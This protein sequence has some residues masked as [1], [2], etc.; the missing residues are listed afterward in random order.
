MRRSLFK[1][2]L[3]VLILLLLGSVPLL[4]QHH[5]DKPNVA[6]PE[7]LSV[8]PENLP[9]QFPG[10]FAFD[11]SPD[12]QTLAVEFIAANDQN[13]QVMQVAEWDIPSKK[14]K[15]TKVVEGP[16]KQLMSNPQ[17]QY[18]LRFTPDGLDL[19]AL[20]GP[21]L[22]ILNAQTLTP[23]RMIGLPPE[24]GPPPKFGWVL[25]SFGISGDG[26]K[27][28]VISRGVGPTCGDY[29]TFRLFGLNSEDLLD[30]WRFRGCTGSIS[31]SEDGTYA[32]LG[33]RANQVEPWRGDL[34]NT[35]TGKIL[36][37]FPG[38]GGVF[39]DDLR[40]IKGVGY[41]DDP[42]PSDERLAALGIVNV[43]TERVEQKLRYGHYGVSGRFAVARISRSVA[44]MESWLDPEDLA[45]DATN[46]RGFVRLI[47]FRASDTEPFY[48]SPDIHDRPMFGA[49]YMARLSSDGRVVAYGGSTIH[50]LKIVYDPSGGSPAGGRVAAP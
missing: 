16:A 14:L 18:D 29:S 3:G 21:R 31:L 6:A 28:A 26:S 46:A 2:A 23:L 30:T 44:V 9:G 34:V 15:I 10:I 45:R 1:G 4:A 8:G 19:V 38:G 27:L 13:D 32:L 20:T 42:K 25:D 40:L 5:T 47:L 33:V 36:R 43:D 39:L 17:F 35:A 37:T 11:V 22:V 48:V 50:V 49:V 7:V 12:G 24:P 41:P